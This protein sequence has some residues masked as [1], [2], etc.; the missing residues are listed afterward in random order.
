M[1]DID[2][3]ERYQREEDLVFVDDTYQRSER[4]FQEQQQR[5]FSRHQQQAPGNQQADNEPPSGYLVAEQQQ[6]RAAAGGRHAPPYQAQ[7]HQLAGADRLPFTQQTSLGATSSDITNVVTKADLEQ[8]LYQQQ[9]RKQQ[10][11]SIKS[12][13]VYSSG[14]SGYHAP[15]LPASRRTPSSQPVGQPLLQHQLQHHPLPGSTVHLSEYTNPINPVD[16]IGLDAAQ[17]QQHATGST[18]YQSHQ[19][20]RQQNPSSIRHHQGQIQQQQQQQQV[21]HALHSTELVHQR[22]G[23]YEQHRHGSGSVFDSGE[24]SS[25]L[26]IRSTGGGGGV[27]GGQHYHASQLPSVGSSSSSALPEVAGSAVAADQL[28]RI[29][30]LFSQNPAI[31]AS[32]PNYAETRTLLGSQMIDS[33]S[34]DYSVE[35]PLS[36]PTAIVSGS[37]GHQHPSSGYPMAGQQQQQAHHHHRQSAASR[38][39]HAAMEASG[40]RSGLAGSSQLN[41]SSLYAASSSTSNVWNMRGR[42]GGGSGATTAEPLPSSST[43]FG[44]SSNTG[45]PI[46]GNPLASGEALSRHSALPSMESS[47]MAAGSD[48]GRVRPVFQ[49]SSSTPTARGNRDRNH[50]SLSPI[51]RMQAQQEQQHQAGQ[52][53]MGGDALHQAGVHH[54]KLASRQTSSS[55]SYLGESSQVAR[56]AQHPH[57]ELEAQPVDEYGSEMLSR[58]MQQ[59]G[60]PQDE[61][62]YYN[63]QQMQHR[64]QQQ[65]Q[66]QRRM[67][68]QI[69][70]PHSPSETHPSFLATGADP[71]DSGRYGAPPDVGAR[72]RRRR[73]SSLELERQQMQL[74]LPGAYETYPD[75]SVGYQHQLAFD[76]RRSQPRQPPTISVSPEFPEDELDLEYL[77]RTGGYD[78]GAPSQRQLEHMRLAGYQTDRFREVK[79]QQPYQ[80]YYAQQVH[81]SATHHPSFQHQHHHHHHSADSRSMAMGSDSELNTRGLS[82]NKLYYVHVP[83]ARRSHRH[84]RQQLSGGSQQHRHRSDLESAPLQPPQMVQQHHH[85]RQLRLGPDDD[86]T[87]PMEG[88]NPVHNRD[89]L[90]GDLMGDSMRGAGRHLPD[91]AH[92]SHPAVHLPDYSMVS[93]SN[94]RPGQPMVA[95]SVAISQEMAA[96]DP[97]APRRQSK[98]VTFDG[99]TSAPVYGRRKRETRERYLRTNSEE[100]GHVDSGDPASQKIDT[101]QMARQPGG[102]H[103]GAEESENEDRSSSIASRT[104]NASYAGSTDQH[105]QGRHHQVGRRSQRAA[106]TASEFNI[107]GTGQGLAS[108]SWLAGDQPHQ[109]PAR[110]ASGSRELRAGRGPEFPVGQMVGEPIAGGKHG[111]GN[112]AKRYPSQHSSTYLEGGSVSDTGGAASISDKEANSSQATALGGS[113]GT[114]PGNKSE[115]RARVRDNQQSSNERSIGDGAGSSQS[116][117]SQM[118]PGTGSGGLSKKSNSTT[119]LSLSGK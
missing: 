103:S 30:Y 68:P 99:R 42:I 7:H 87:M 49:K 100:Y 71:A 13:M 40:G 38:A 62:Q 91:T 41:S 34:L 84:Q 88:F 113:T 55:G 10:R 106:I 43:S 18:Y 1:A 75:D 83:P 56:P 86:D 70:R 61:L 57:V 39:R 22:R 2:D 76:D 97:Q 6:R 105:P 98:G 117:K 69:P 115:R 44:W 37:G 60:R 11:A 73:Q 26:G 118:G 51:S 32:L 59:L 66:Q 79:Q 47:S 119:Q 29:G 20:H 58:M 53:A 36:L 8:Q 3:L 23:H 102:Q 89:E 24:G 15:T 78:V 50:E 27:T 82:S 80:Q 65:Q 21:G 25:S 74:A 5:P 77:Q 85:Q 90:A 92:H 96:R 46:G 67:L 101:R 54:Q 107:T 104:S 19:Q 45:G 109:Q 33:G 93:T 14:D 31:S 108:D 114:P 17:Q 72:H 111:S 16:S 63:Q 110:L 94:I 116:L 52:M 35:E 64:Q 95:S 12:L 28:P 9:H 81:H 48:R 4:H 112:G